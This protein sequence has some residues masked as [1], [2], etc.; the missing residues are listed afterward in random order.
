MI[1]VKSTSTVNVM[2]LLECWIIFQMMQFNDF[3]N[4]DFDQKSVSKL[5]LIRISRGPFLYFYIL[6]QVIHRMSN[7]NNSSL[8]LTQGFLIKTYTTMYSY[9]STYPFVKLFLL[10]NFYFLGALPHYLIFLLPRTNLSRITNR[11]R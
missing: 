10:I 4:V 1:T 7:I 5:S 8:F 11:R 9:F 3:M 6:L 2:Q